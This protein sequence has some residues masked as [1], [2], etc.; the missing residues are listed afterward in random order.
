MQKLLLMKMRKFKESKEMRKNQRLRRLSKSKNLKLKMNQLMNLP[1]N[2]L[3]DS[4]RLFKQKKL[5]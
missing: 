4:S 2:S 5:L 3:I 1:S